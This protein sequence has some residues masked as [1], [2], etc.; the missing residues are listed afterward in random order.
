MNS[1]MIQKF[2]VFRGKQPNYAFGA[3]ATIGAPKFECPSGG[4]E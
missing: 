1:E 4:K 3:S 2:M